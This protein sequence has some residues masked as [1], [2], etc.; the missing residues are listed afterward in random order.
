MGGR[1]VLILGSGFGGTYTLR[2]LVPSLNL[3]ENIET[4]MVSDENFFLFSPLLH[5]VATGRIAVSRE[6]CVRL[7]GSA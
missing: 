5:E 7:P 3:N 4:T 2:N 6:L 1:K